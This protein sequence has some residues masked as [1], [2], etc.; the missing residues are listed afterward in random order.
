MEQYTLTFL[1]EDTD[2][3]P[4]SIGSQDKSNVIGASR[5]HLL[6]GV[7]PWYPVMGEFHYS[8]YPSREWEIELRKMKALGITI[9]ATDV[10]WIHH[11]E[12]KG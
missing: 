9:V 7:K 8:R 1:P 6:R 11:E 2:N 5:H 3:S 4:D 12:E 10:F